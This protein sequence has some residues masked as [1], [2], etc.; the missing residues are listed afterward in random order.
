MQ[1]TSSNFSLHSLTLCSIHLSIIQVQTLGSLCSPTILPSSLS[2]LSPEPHS[3]PSITTPAPARPAQTAAARFIAVPELRQL[4]FAALDNRSLA[5]WARVEKGLTYDVA[6]EL[7]R[8]VEMV[9][10][11]NRMSR[12]GVSLLYSCEHRQ[13]A[14]E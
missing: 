11:R 2:P 13:E 4:L 5:Q 3:A 10:L 6:R 14:E 9:V 12:V 1:L 7:Y 8:T